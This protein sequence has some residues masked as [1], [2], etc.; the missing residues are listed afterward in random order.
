[1]SKVILSYILKNFLKYF[2]I[3]V[4][5]IY[6]FGVILNLFEEI[7]FFKKIDANIFLPFMLT[8]I[9]VPSMIINLLPFIIFISSMLY[10]IKIRNNKDLLTLKIN[11]FSNIKIF[12]IFAFTS[13]F[14]GWLILI[15]INPITSSM[16]QFYEKTK[17]QYAR[18]IDHLVSFN[19]NGLWIKETLNN[20]SRIITAKKPEGTNLI[21][22]EIFHFDKNFLLKKK[23]YSKTASIKNYDW[24]LTNAAVFESKN[25]VFVK[26]EFEKYKILSKYNHEK[27]INLFNNSNT[28]SFID[29]VFNYR[30]LLDKGYNSSFLNESLHLMLV[31]PFFL[32]LMTAVASVLTMHTLRRSEN[33][34]FIIVGLATCVLV[35][36]FKDL[37]L[38]LGKTGRIPI[39]LS[40]WS[41]IIALSLFSFIGI[42]QINEK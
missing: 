10:M 27:I 22:V 21:D 38:A 41:P 11:G 39:I 42:L 28:I 12:L 13:F 31:L 25:S 2:C 24:V 30:E 16:L 4:L 29:L 8:S 18:D 9:F 36:Y 33:L 23:I 6:G 40:I 20:E 17:S 19:K 3:L 35:Y 37:S 32:F 15:I 7:E 34:K 5:I 14:L 1:M 26:K